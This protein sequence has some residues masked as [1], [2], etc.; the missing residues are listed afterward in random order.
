MSAAFTSQGAWFTS[1]R[2]A[3]TGIGMLRSIV[4]LSLFDPA[5]YGGWI[6]ASTILLYSDQIHLGLRHVG[7]RDL[8]VILGREGEIVRERRAQILF[9]QVVLVS[10][11]V[12]VIL[13]V[14]A[15]SGWTLQGL[16]L[17]E[18]VSL[19]SIVVADQAMK[20]VLMVQRTMRQFRKTSLWE[21]SIEGTKSVAII[22]GA[23]V[24]GLTGA[25]VGFSIAAS[26]SAVAIM[27][28]ERFRLSVLSETVRSLTSSLKLGFPL[29]VSGALLTAQ[30]A[31]DRLFGTAFLSS[32]ALGYYGVAAL[33][34]GIPILLAQSIAVVSYPRLTT[35]LPDDLSRI[36]RRLLGLTAVLSL[37]GGALSVH[38][39]QVLLE[40]WVPQYR[41]ASA[42][43]AILMVGTV[44]FGA[45]SPVIQILLA[46]RKNRACVWRQTLGTALVGLILIMWGFSFPHDIAVLSVFSASGFLIMAGVVSTGLRT[47][48]SPDRSDGRRAMFVF[49]GV[50]L[51]GLYAA[52]QQYLSHS[53]L[54]GPL[55]GTI[56]LLVVAIGLAVA[57]W[58][59]LAMPSVRLLNGELS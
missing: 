8:P 43:I 44:G 25:I 13:V 19:G 22:G 20:F 37:V 36:S 9:S 21:L 32:E 12:S 5:A 31:L 28:G 55:F 35:A 1:A 2:L 52:A 38:A 46:A 18:L 4:L 15:T 33:A 51:I 14:A 26:C 57:G 58:R 29:A 6:A 30:M 3:L 24:G 42:S 27:F 45:V 47:V 11:V 39:S 40:F 17:Q 41:P 23:L 59:L 53:M 56:I 48:I 34:A 16:G 50:M 7:E 54:P 49:G 10:F